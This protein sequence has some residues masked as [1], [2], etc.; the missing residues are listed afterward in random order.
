ML[1]KD[2]C[3]FCSLT[4]QSAPQLFLY[5]SKKLLPAIKISSHMEENQS[6][7]HLKGLKEKTLLL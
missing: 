7:H 1:K 2:A 6:M 3:G 5:P 4:T